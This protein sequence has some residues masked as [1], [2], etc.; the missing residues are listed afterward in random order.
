MTRDELELLREDWDFEAKLAQGRDG[1]GE[2]PESFWE[3]YSAMA[4]SDGGEIILGIKERSDHSLEISGLQDI[5]RIEH[6]IWDLLHN[7]EKVSINLLDRKHVRRETIEGLDIL[8]IEIPRAE[9][10]QRPVFIN[11]NPLTGTYRRRL[12]GDYRCREDEVRRMMADADARPRDGAVL[13]HFGLN[14]LDAES[15]AVYRNLFRSNTPSHP[16]LAGDDQELLR[17]LGGWAQDRETGDEGITLAG[18]VMFGKGRAILDHLPHFHLDYQEIPPPEPKAPRWLD[19]ITLD[20]TWAGNVFQFYRR[21][22]PKLTEGLKVPFQMQ[23]PGM[24]RRDETPVHEAL[25]EALVNALI[26]ADYSGTTGI[27]VFKKADS[28]EFINPGGLRL[29]LDQIWK[30][31]TSDCRNPSVQKMFQMIGAGEKA[32][33]GIPKITSAWAEQEWREPSIIENADLNETTLRLTLVG[34]YP[35]DVL[36]RL[37]ERFGRSL[38]DLTN[39]ERATLV[40]VAARQRAEHGDLLEVV[41][42]HPRDLTVALQVL[43]RKGMLQK[44]RPGRGCTYRVAEPVGPQHKV[45]RSQDKPLGSGLQGV[46]VDYVLEQGQ[47]KRADVVRLCNISDDQATRL[48]KKMT[49]GG[50]L[51]Q[52]GKKRWTRYLPGPLLAIGKR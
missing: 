16:F 1:R 8:A 41:G 13:N 49:D 28:F 14:D 26:H 43:Q 44:D 22:Y 48:L 36:T 29:P 19:R 7:R 25:R 42:G 46:V 39:K 9:R 24:T 5:E 34:L 32:G 3:T 10:S 21:V 33:S 50:F 17:Q 15:I 20:G 23:L 51:E 52:H 31:G 12:D 47:I 27:R 40:A 30:G 45:S 35:Q 37:K 11:G 4:N 6:T 2:L 18:L 38:A